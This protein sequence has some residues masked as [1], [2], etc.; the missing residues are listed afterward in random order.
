MEKGKILVSKSKKGKIIIELELEN[1]SKM[2]V[3]DKINY[4]NKEELNNKDV[5]F[6]RVKGQI[7]RIVYNNENIFAGN[8][9]QT[10]PDTDSDTNP[11]ALEIQNPAI[12]P[13]NFIPL[14][15]KVVKTDFD[16]NKFSFNKYH[17]NL[18]TGY[19]DLEIEA[20]TDLYIR[21]TNAKDNPDFFS[22]AGKYRIPGSS[23][24]G[25]LRN[26]VEIVSFGKFG[27]IH[28]RRL[29]FRSFADMAR[30]LR[31]AFSSR[32]TSLKNGKPVANSQ[33]GFF[34]RTGLNYEIIPADSVK[35]L[36]MKK[37]YVFDDGRN[38]VY[39]IAEFVP[40]NNGIG[41]RAYY[42][43][44]N[45]D[46]D[47]YKTINPT[48]LLAYM[49]SEK[50]KDIVK[51]LDLYQEIST[52]QNS[53]FIGLNDKFKI[54][55]VKKHV[56]KLAMF[57]KIDSKG[58][59]VEISHKRLGNNCYGCLLKKTGDEIKVCFQGIIEAEDG[60]TRGERQN[61]QR[62]APQ[63]Y[64]KLKD[65]NYYLVTGDMDNKKNNFL[66]TLNN[67][68]K[69]ALEI[70]KFEID[71]YKDDKNRK[72]PNLVEIANKKRN[73]YIPMFYSGSGKDLFF[74]TT[75][76]FRLGYKKTTAQL[77]TINN[78]ESID[79]ATS[80]FGIE[81]KEHQGFATRL[82]VE[83]QYLEKDSYE[84]IEQTV[85]TPKILA[86]P[87]PTSF[88]HYLVQTTNDIAKLNHYD[89]NSSKIRGNKLYWH[90]DGKNWT[91]AQEDVNQHPTQ[92]TK[93]KPIKAGAVFKGRIR[94]ENLTNVELGALLF[95]LTLKDNLCHKIGMGKPLGLGSIK[96]TP[97]LYLSNRTERYKKLF[98]EWGEIKNEA[99]ESVNNIIS[100]F[101]KYILNQTGE[102]KDSIWNIN[103]MKE[104]QKMLDFTN[105]PANNKTEYM[106]LQEFRDR[107][108]LPIPT[109][110]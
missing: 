56:S 68:D 72:G 94:F 79:I 53:N 69:E 8:T 67:K 70:T 101:E 81:S 93:I 91:A 89:S 21:D 82:F 16:I 3:T 105:K 62:N 75:K 84:K 74:G 27:F 86:S 110:I 77:L 2:T 106:V 22:P 65:N 61:N 6:E 107:R 7:T 31:D 99:P 37:Y 57:C 96:I 71:S 19:I 33:G 49:N 35:Y 108:I 83:D 66:L 14:N 64:V 36:K 100:S 51:I 26:L 63:Y 38:V 90:K 32:M 58:D 103:R 47:K 11:N 54:D 97:T 46:N 85:K 28:D 76:M 88:Q 30:T 18:K 52:V 92:Y 109:Q 102:N 55:E 17:S 80:I 25:M 59:V 24:R 5:E 20:K 43:K 50:R 95:S 39:S 98:E 40:N 44:F 1:K 15:E 34:H 4:K 87:N 42:Y 29:Y 60:R 9:N 10:N 73:E 23:L 45:V 104:L 41:E 78:T 48:V 13:Y 12:S